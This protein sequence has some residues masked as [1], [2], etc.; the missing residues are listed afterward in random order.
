MTALIIVAGVLGYFMLGAVLRPLL[1]RTE[2][3]HDA[4][5]FGPTSAPID[6]GMAC[7]L[8][9]FFAPLAVLFGLLKIAGW[10]A[11]GRRHVG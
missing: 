11:G 9:P 7:L 4:A 8:A 1:G 6:A 10:L 2:M 5:G 3:F